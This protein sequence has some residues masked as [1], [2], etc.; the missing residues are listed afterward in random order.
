MSLALGIQLCRLSLMRSS[1]SH[2]TI[3][4]MVTFLI[5][6]QLLSPVTVLN[7]RNGSVALSILG[8]HI[9]KEGD[10]YHWTPLPQTAGTGEEEQWQNV[11]LTRQMG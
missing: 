11:V 3:Y 4:N 1:L 9:H 10:L 7:I 8:V 2:V 5:Y 6:G